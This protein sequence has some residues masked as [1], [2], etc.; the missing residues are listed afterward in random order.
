MRSRLLL[1]CGI[2]AVAACNSGNPPAA[3]HQ[4][5]PETKKLEAA[6]VAGYDGKA[7]RKSVDKSMDE[8]DAHSDDLN[9]ALK[10]ARE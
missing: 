8:V 4:G 2:F 10:S 5:R 7:V 3:K 9:K 1:I 6:S